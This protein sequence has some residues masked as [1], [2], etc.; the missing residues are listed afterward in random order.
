MALQSDEKLKNLLNAWIPQTIATSAWLNGLGISRQLAR[1][2]TSHRWLD[3]VGT[4]AFKRP[5]ETVAWFGAVYSLQNQLKLPVHAG[6]LTAIAAHGLSHYLRMGRETVYLFSPSGIRLPTWFT[7][8]KWNN[9]IRHVKSGLLPDHLGL[10]K[11]A[12]GSIEITASM[13]ERAILECLY[14]CPEKLGLL[15]CYE[16]TQGLMN[17]RPK[18]MQALL[19]ACAS[20][21]VK[22]LFLYMA[23]KANLP[24]MRHLDTGKI[25]LGSGDRSLAANGV[26]N[27]KY[28]LVVPAEL[29]NH[30]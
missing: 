26:Y 28:R 6:A 16:I 17:L 20:I 18:V 13:P 25:E 5:Q 3:S 24:V 11:V 12:Y 7:A 9:P 10:T 15:E 30:N 2:Y 19:E 1:H 29:A 23:D 22:R 27:S 8:R 14:L 4:G 21:K